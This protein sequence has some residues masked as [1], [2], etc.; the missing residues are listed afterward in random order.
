MKFEE[1]IKLFK[2]GLPIRRSSS[3]VTYVMRSGPESWN[4]TFNVSDVLEDDWA[5]AV[6]RATI[7]SKTLG[8]N[9][10]FEACL[11]PLGLAAVREDEQEHFEPASVFWREDGAIWTHIAGRTQQKYQ[12]HYLLAEIE[13][14]IDALHPSRAPAKPSV[15]ASNRP[16]L[17][18]RYK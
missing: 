13:S 11:S 15:C 9:V 6:R 1:A 17:K 16:L 18:D 3:D 7:F 5:V 2:E 8:K 14:A 12:G 10:I 4:I